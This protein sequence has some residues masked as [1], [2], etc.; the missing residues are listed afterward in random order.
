MSAKQGRTIPLTRNL[1]RAAER[2]RAIRNLQLTEQE[3]EENNLSLINQTTMT[4]RTNRDVMDELQIP[5]AIKL[6][7][8]YDGDKELLNKF[9]TSVERVLKLITNIDKTAYG[10][11]L[12]GVIRDKVIGHA[13]KILIRERVPLNWDDI[14]QALTDNFGESRSEENLMDDLREIPYKKL[15]IKNLY[16]EIAGIRVAMLEV[17]ER[18]ETNIEIRK[19][20]ESSYEKTYIQKFIAGLKNPLRWT[21]KAQNP[22]TLRQANEIAKELRDDY[23]RDRNRD[24]YHNPGGRG[25]GR[26]QYNNS[27]RYNSEQQQYNNTTN[28]DEQRNNNYKRG[29]DR[30]NDDSN[31]NRGQHQ[32]R[33]RFSG[34]S[35]RGRNYQGSTRSGNGTNS[36]RSQQSGSSGHNNMFHT[37]ASNT[38]QTEN[39]SVNASEPQTIPNNQDSERNSFMSR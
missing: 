8:T 1:V 32:K 13:D 21:V 2:E 5:D 11:L 18:D 23:I 10:E 30:S 33:G 4:Q 19:I 26:G 15:A 24:E 38:N 9:I 29:R 37:E 25:R 31:S 17:L 22:K 16:Q 20:K 6:L 34:S 14:K 39:F 35:D 12:L 28:N 27:Y 36:D 7:P 3:E